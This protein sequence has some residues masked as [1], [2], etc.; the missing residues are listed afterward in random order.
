MF[1]AQQYSSSS[2]VV[3]GRGIHTGLDFRLT[4]ELTEQS[5]GIQFFAT[6]SDGSSC[7]APA[8]WTRLSGTNRSTALVLRG[9]NRQRV[10]L[11][12]IEHFL[13]A[14]Y[15]FSLPSLNVTIQCISQS[16]TDFEFPI[17]EGASEKWFRVLENL[18]SKSSTPP[19]DKLRPL[20]RVV[21]PFELKDG[22]RSITL[23]PLAKDSTEN[24]WTCIVD[25]GPSWR[26]EMN[27]EMDWLRPE[28]GKRK[29]LE[30]I[31][32]ARTFGF[33]HELQS[34]AKRGLA[35]GAE[36]ENALLLGDKGVVNAGGFKIQNELAAHKLLD[37]MGDFAL[38]G[39]PLVGAVRCVRA[40]HSMHVQAV[41]EAVLTGAVKL[42]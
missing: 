34:L 6:M 23:T 31:A 35:K 41:K 32:P 7:S 36:L 16:D 42:I 3:E 19:S 1:A 5:K 30:S 26:Q 14:A 11:R 9:P 12:T 20:W 4:L 28:A 27:F 29:F 33:E 38:L 18:L 21:S 13:A 2:E 10:A 15:V 8:S 24:L 37:A 40:G 17:L 39:A 22:D 25:Y